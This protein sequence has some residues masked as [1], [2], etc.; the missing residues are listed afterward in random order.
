VGAFVKSWFIHLLSHLCSEVTGQ[1]VDNTEVTYSKQ[2]T[3]F[4]RLETSRLIIRRFREDDIPALTAYRSDPNVYRYLPWDSYDENKARALVEELKDKEPGEPG[5]YFF[6][7]EDKS[8]RK[9]I[10]DLYLRTEDDKRLA[11]IGY[12]F[13]LSSQGKGLATEAVRAL[14][15]YA[16]GTLQM[17]RLIARA[18]ADNAASLKLL[19][20]FGF[21]KEAHFV[22]SFWYRGAWMDTVVYALL[23]EEWQAKNN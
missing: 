12:V 21:R 8:T 13:A 3:G 2:S 7:L 5:R 11:E 9:L 22:K 4:E 10:G 1:V 15:E 19:E 18:V 16:F 14:L 20:R 6:A 23:G 17:H